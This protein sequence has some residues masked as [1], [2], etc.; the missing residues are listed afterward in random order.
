MVH[1]DACDD[2]EAVGD[3]VLH[4]SEQ[5]IFVLQQLRRLPSGDAPAFNRKVHVS[6]LHIH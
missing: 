3:T 6:P 2:L 1:E 5:N 4:L